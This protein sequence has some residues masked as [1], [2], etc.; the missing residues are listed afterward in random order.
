MVVEAN[1]Q[2]LQPTAAQPQSRNNIANTKNN[3]EAV[4]SQQLSMHRLNWGLAAAA[5]AAAHAA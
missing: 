5:A 3:T 1:N 2:P 4:L